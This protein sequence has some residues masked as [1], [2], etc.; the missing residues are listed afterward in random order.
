V[1]RSL[2]ARRQNRRLGVGS[3]P[4]HNPPI[5]FSFDAAMRPEEPD[6]S[7]RCW[8]W[9]LISSHES[10]DSL[11]YHRRRLLLGLFGVQY[12]TMSGTWRWHTAILPLMMRRLARAL[13]WCG[14]VWLSLH[15]HQLN[16]TGASRSKRHHQSLRDQHSTTAQ[17]R[18]GAPADTQSTAR[19]AQSCQADRSIAS[20]GKRARNCQRPRQNATPV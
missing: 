12:S 7:V 18:T 16:L 4:S 8:R 19:T 2:R 9:Q 13:A 11:S 20:S 1:L 17:H 3:L 5:I 10:L 14:M 6:T 15:R